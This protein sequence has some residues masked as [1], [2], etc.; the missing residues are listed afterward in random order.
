MAEDMKKTQNGHETSCETHHGHSHDNG[1]EHGHNSG[2]L[3][4]IIHH[5]P[6]AIFSVSAAFILLSFIDFIGR[7]FPYSHDLSL[8]YDTLFH[9]FH[10][11]HI[12][13]AATG[14]LLTF[15]RFS[16]N[17]KLALLVGSITPSFFC[18]LSDGILPY[19]AGTL[20]GVD[21]ELHLCFVTELHNV[22]PFLLVGMLNGYLL[23]KHDS[24]VRSF[25]YICSHFLHI[26]VSALAALFYLVSH[27]LNNWYP[28]MGYMYLFLVLVVVIP[29]T[30]SDVIVPLYFARKKRKQ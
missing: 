11:L 22:L 19:Y 9:S 23:S 4:E 20:L 7:L 6:Y 3:Q 21:M 10:F 29:C 12:I 13:F 18:I 2:F 1:Y 25:F 28:L 5:T 26:F 8:G 17:K 14:T 27:G 15:F 30:L 16:D 24:Q